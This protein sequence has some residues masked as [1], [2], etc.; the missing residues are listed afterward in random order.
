MCAEEPAVPAVFQKV[1][2]LFSI[3]MNCTG[4]E[5]CE[6][7]NQTHK[8]KPF[9]L[10]KLSNRIK[11]LLCLL[12]EP[13]TNM[14]LPK[15]SSHGQVQLHISYLWTSNNIKHD[16][17]FCWNLS[18]FQLLNTYVDPT[19]WAWD[20]RCHLL[21]AFQTLQ[22]KEK[23]SFSQA[24]IWLLH[25]KMFTLLPILFFFP[26]EINLNT[27]TKSVVSLLPFLD[28]KKRWVS[29]SKKLNFSIL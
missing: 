8:I 1:F 12:I 3:P 11:V 20:L 9:N 16:Q 18:F 28:A 10:G 23:F 2:M 15:H 29:L 14:L 17:I 27:F 6:K 7:N 25:H 22:A 24:F 26:L 4:E 21:H 13:P 19:H 5:N